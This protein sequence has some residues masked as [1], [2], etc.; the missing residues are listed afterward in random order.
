MCGGCGP[1]LPFALVS[2]QPVLVVVLVIDGVACVVGNDDVHVLMCMDGHGDRCWLSVVVVGSTLAFANARP[3]SWVLMVGGC[4]LCGQ[5]GP[6]W[7]VMGSRRSWEAGVS[8][9]HG[10]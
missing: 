5:S 4:C 3:R 2:A 6:F 8:I 10:W 9:C 1:W 7:V